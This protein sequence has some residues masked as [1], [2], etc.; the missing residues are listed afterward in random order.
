MSRF[1][2]FII[3]GNIKGYNDKP[4]HEEP[5]NRKPIEMKKGDLSAAI[6]HCEDLINKEKAKGK[7]A[8]PQK[9]SHLSQMIRTHKMKQ[10]MM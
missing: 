9:I 5:S 1:E 10:A 8:D 4:Y 6:A 2:E 7:F 3:E